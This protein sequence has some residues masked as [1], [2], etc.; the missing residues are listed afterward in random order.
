MRAN[1]TETKP[2][3]ETAARETLR[4]CSIDW[5]VEDFGDTRC[6]MLA[7]GEAEGGYSTADP[8][9]LDRDEL[10]ALRA[11]IDHLIDVLDA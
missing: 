5:Y 7:V 11:V 6:A 8:E 2:F 3:D 4:H 9:R 10:I 1:E